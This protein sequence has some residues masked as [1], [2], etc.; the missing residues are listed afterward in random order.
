MLLRYCE[1]PLGVPSS[2]RRLAAQRVQNRRIVT[3][4]SL[5][6]RM[7]DHIGA[8]K[9]GS[10]SCDG[11]VDM[12]EN[13]EHPRGESQDGYSGVLTGRA[14]SHLVGFRTCVEHIERAF[15]RLAGLDAC[16]P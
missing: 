16:A 12:A 3:G 11:R 9:R 15:D 2:D 5:R 10:H 13:P 6:V 7:V 14:R 1:T 4:V 8:F